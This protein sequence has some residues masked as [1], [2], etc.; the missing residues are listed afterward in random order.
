[1]IRLK[2]ITLDLHQ[3][4]PKIIFSHMSLQLFKIF[5]PY[6]DKIFGIDNYQVKSNKSVYVYCDMSHT[7]YRDVFQVVKQLKHAQLDFAIR[8]PDEFGSYENGDD[9][10]VLEDYLRIKDFMLQNRNK[11]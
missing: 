4:V 1:M 7:R 8:L 6:F 9:F 10:Y 11:V 5:Q 2:E 3:P